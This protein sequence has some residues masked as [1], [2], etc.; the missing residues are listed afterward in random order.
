MGRGRVGLGRERLG[1]GRGKIRWGWEEKGDSL[2]EEEQGRLKGRVEQNR[3]RRE[4][5][6]APGGIQRGIG[7]GKRGKTGCGEGGR[8]LRG[9]EGERVSHRDGGH[10][11]VRPQGPPQL[12]PPG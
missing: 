8:L 1:R 3:L 9:R 6:G 12:L 7:W 2:S 4:R 10:L 11:P 5:G